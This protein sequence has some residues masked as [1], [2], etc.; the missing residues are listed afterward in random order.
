MSPQ[1]YPTRW[2]DI[3][4]KNTQ[5]FRETFSSISHEQMNWKPDPTTWSIG[6]NIDH[7]LVTNA[8][9]FPIIESIR[10]GI[11]KVPWIPSRSFLVKFNEK[12]IMDY[13]K[14]ERAK[15]TK[16]IPI[17][18]PTQ[19][20]VEEG[21]LQKFIQEQENLKDLITNSQDLVEAGT[22]ISSPFSKF[23]VYHLEAAYDIIVTHEQRHLAQ[24]KEVLSQLP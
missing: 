8:S 10:A 20:Q 1:T 24:A 15:K 4:D 7:L 11:Y 14:P 13:V 6:Q 18:E 23:I 9:F 16:T 2:L 12:M 5:D 19:S 21:V 17:W 3:I 22:K